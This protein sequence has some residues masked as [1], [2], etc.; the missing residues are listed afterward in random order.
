MIMPQSISKSKR[1]QRTLHKS[2]LWRQN[3]E[4]MVLSGGPVSIWEMNVNSPHALAMTFMFGEN[5]LKVINDHATKY[6]WMKMKFLE[7]SLIVKTW[8]IAQFLIS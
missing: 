5:L 4:N 6:Q 1:R 3:V 8:K 7:F 2:I